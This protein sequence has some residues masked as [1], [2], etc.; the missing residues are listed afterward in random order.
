GI[1]NTFFMFPG[2]GVLALIFIYFMVPETRN[3]TLEDLEE[4]FRT[5]YGR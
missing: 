3:K 1:A 5:K 2:L 4:E